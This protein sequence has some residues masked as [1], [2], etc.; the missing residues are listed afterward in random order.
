MKAIGS[1]DSASLTARRIA[2]ISKSGRTGCPNFDP[3]QRLVA[4]RR[5]QVDHVGRSAL[6]VAVVS[7]LDHPDDLEGVGAEIGAAPQ[8]LPIAS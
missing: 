7:V 6:Q 2:V 1:R 8:R 4:L 5:G 3:G